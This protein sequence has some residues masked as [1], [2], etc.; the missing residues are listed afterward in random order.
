MTRI[1]FYDLPKNLQGFLVALPRTVEFRDG[2]QVPRVGLRVNRR[3]NFS[4]IQIKFDLRLV[5]MPLFT[6]KIRQGQTECDPEI[7]PV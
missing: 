1:H 3:L 6:Q 5:P 2:K 4:P 7:D